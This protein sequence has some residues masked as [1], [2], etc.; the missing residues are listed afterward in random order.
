MVL[1]F[2]SCSARLPVYMLL[3]TACMPIGRLGRGAVL[4]GL[5]ALGILATFGA[6]WVIK[7][8]SSRS[9]S[10]GFI[11]EL[12]PYHRPHAKTV[13][14]LVWE[15][16]REFLVRAGTIILA[17]TVVL[18]A[19]TSYPQGSAPA[20][21]SAQAAVRAEVD[22]DG[23]DGAQAGSGGVE[24]GRGA[25]QL[26]HSYAGRLGRLIEPVIRPLGFNWEI[27]VGLI[28]SFTAREVFVST[29]GIVYG[30]GE[31]GEG[32]VSLRE[33]MRAATWPDG[34]K[35]FTPL[36]A[37]GLLVYTVLACQCIPTLAVVRQETNGWR[38][39]VVMFVYMTAVAYVAAL[40]IYQ[41]GTALG[42]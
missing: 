23:P 5:Y 24:R 18:W 37:V 36:V 42:L 39:P 16:C 4:C 35:L 27:G 20:G 21:A 29:M 7:Q 6:A 2:I 9:G 10:P 19:L 14:V 31:T 34:S 8:G 3:I 11:I 15:R 1:P 17:A 25:R 12:P 26:R 28:S 22:G 33:R 38:W 30:A 32:S 41:A 40:V 13:A